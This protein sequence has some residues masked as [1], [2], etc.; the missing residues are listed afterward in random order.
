[1][2]L[3]EALLRTDEGISFRGKMSDLH[4]WLIN[5][6]AGLDNLFEL[7]RNKISTVMTFDGALYL[8]PLREYVD[9]NSEPPGY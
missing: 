4:W 1:M 3:C 7:G 5:T 2:E 6:S 8:P 9:A